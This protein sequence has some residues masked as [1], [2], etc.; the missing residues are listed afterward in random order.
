MLRR[1][2]RL[3]NIYPKRNDMLLERKWLASLRRCRLLSHKCQRHHHQPL[4]GR[5]SGWM[6]LYHWTE[7]MTL[8]QKNSHGKFIQK[9]ATVGIVDWKK[10]TILNET[11]YHKAGSYKVNSY[12]KKIKVSKALF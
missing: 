1:G 11:V 4:G 9:A 3:I 6:D 2:N 5:R 10:D 8:N 7:M 12:T